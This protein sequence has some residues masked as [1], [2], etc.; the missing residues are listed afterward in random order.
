M[1]IKP[2]ETHYK[3]YRFRSRLE[4]RWAVFF[5]SMGIEYQYELEGFEFPNGTRYLPDFF[6]PCPEY[7]KESIPALPDGKWVEVKGSK[8]PTEEEQNKLF[9]LSQMTGQECVMLCGTVGDQEVYTA[10]DGKLHKR[11]FPEIDSRF[12]LFTL[13]F[14]ATPELVSRIEKAITAARSARFEFG[15][16]TTPGKDDR[17]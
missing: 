11:V 7:M 15:E 5:D 12:R 4:A 2:I 16:T 3:G 6:L 8:T 9:L 10:F 14:L 1:K 17:E 13:L